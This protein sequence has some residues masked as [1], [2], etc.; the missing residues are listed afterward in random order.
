MECCLELN[1]LWMQFSPSLRR[2]PR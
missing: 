1:S 2:K